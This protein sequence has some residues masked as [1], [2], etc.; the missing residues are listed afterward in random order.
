MDELQPYKPEKTWF[1]E[2]GDG[3]ILAMN[4]LQAWETLKNRTNWMR[5]DFK[6][7]GVSDGTTHHR[8]ANELRAQTKDAK[9]AVKK[10]NLELTRYIETKD[11]LKFDELLSDDDP[12]VE[13]VDAL[14]SEAEA[15]LEKAQKEFQRVSADIGEQAFKA[16]LEVAKGNIE[17][18]SNQNIMTPR[19]TEQEKQIIRKN[20][21]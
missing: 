4:E 9:E 1:I 17:Q 18:P 3:K 15:K 19:A 7:I 5:S 21:R 13:R 12:K 20:I 8:V 10:A 11:R 16:E 2:R 6:I 14:I